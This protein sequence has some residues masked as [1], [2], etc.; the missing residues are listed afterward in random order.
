MLKYR[1]ED[2]ASLCALSYYDVEHFQKGMLLSQFLKESLEKTDNTSVFFKSL[3]DY[4]KKQ[5]FHSICNLKMVDYVNENKSS[6][7]VY[8]CYEDDSNYYVVYRGSELYHPKYYK[9]AWQDWI[10]NLEIFLGIT[11]QQLQ[12]HKRLN[13]LEI[14]KPIYL[15]GHSKGGNLALFLGI[16]CSNQIYQNIEKIIAFN[17][18][19]M[20][21]EIL[22]MYVRRMN[23][24]SFQNKIICIENEM[25]LV[26]SMFSHV[27][28]PLLVQS[29]Y[30]ENTFSDAYE[31]HQIWGFEKE[32]EI[33]RI[34][35]KKG[36]IAEC[37][38]FMT[39]Q[40]INQLNKQNQKKIVNQILNICKDENVRIMIQNKIESWVN[41]VEINK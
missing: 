4:L 28:Q 41:D 27:H 39:N 33:F 20:N 32:N 24:S 26:S 9:N 13:A 23:E 12:A 17:A 29:I 30:K 2:F 19:G 10:D 11:H 3:S 37:V 21:Q 22:D 36:R 35:V 25:D 16:T 14:E 38:D 6:G 7:L 18:F 1:V 34:G 31:S 8:Y 5:E 40:F 15:I